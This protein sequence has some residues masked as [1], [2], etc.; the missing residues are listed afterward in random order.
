MRFNINFFFLPQPLFLKI[1]PH[2]GKFLFLLIFSFLFDLFTFPILYP[3]PISPH[4]PPVLSPL[5]LLLWGCAPT[6]SPAPA[7]LPSHSPTMGHRDFTGP[8]TSSLIDACQGHPVL[9]IFLEPW[10]APCVLLGCWFRLWELWL[11]DIIV[12]PVGLQT[13]S[14]PF[15]LSLGNPKSVQ[16]LAVSIHLCICQAHV[17]G[18]FVI[19]FLRISGNSCQG[20][21]SSYPFWSLSLFYLKKI[22]PYT[23]YVKVSIAI[24]IIMLD[25]ILWMHFKY[26]L[27]FSGTSS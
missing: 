24:M 15:S 23:S 10:V 8:R 2:L 1:W 7:S 12:L 27:N 21:T 4:N 3:F 9:H 13:P 11:F 22:F 17:N 20:Y 16:W 18:R 26:T 6:H 19:I 5:L 25:Y 14:A